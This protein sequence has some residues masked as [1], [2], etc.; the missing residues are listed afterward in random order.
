V[1]VLNLQVPNIGEAVHELT[2]KGIQFVHYE[3]AD[4]LGIMH[5]DGPVIAWF[6]DPDGNFISVVQED[7]LYTG[8]ADKNISSSSRDF[9]YE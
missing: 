9:L 6:K 1:T 5:D 3:G 8:I 7:S 2:N 4:Q